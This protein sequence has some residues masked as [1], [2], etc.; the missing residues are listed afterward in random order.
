MACDVLFKLFS[1]LFAR[2]MFYSN[3]SYYFMR[4]V[5]QI[6]DGCLIRHE[7]DSFGGNT[8]TVS[9]DVI[10][11]R[12]F[13]RQG[14]P[15]GGAGYILSREACFL[16]PGLPKWW[17]GLNPQQGSVF[18]VA[19]VTQ[20]V[21]RDTSSAG[22]RAFCRQGYPSGGAGCILSRET[23]S[24]STGLPKWWWCG[25]HPQQG[26]VL[27]VARVTQVVVRAASSA[28]KR[29]LCRQGYPSGGAGYILS[30]EALKRF[31]NRPRR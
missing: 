23:C 31:A 27:S 10:C 30:R 14:Y 11:P 15:S 18:S 21:V 13:C 20:V 4:K 28:G 6:Y 3:Q 17:C 7:H 12:V 9:F 1:D 24:L 29:V 19:R 5:I 8:S 25:I 22:K 26:S 16:S 2:D